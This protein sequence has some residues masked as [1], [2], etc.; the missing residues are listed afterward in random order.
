LGPILWDFDALTMTFWRL[1]RRVRWEGV[2]GASLVTPQHQLAT[3]TT[4]AEHPLLDHLL[5]Q[6]GDLFTEPRGLP[7]ARVYDHCIHLQPGSG[8]VVV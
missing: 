5:Q 3:T 1:G 7:P 8:P 4:E 2:G 6:H